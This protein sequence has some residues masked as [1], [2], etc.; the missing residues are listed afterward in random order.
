MRA[1]LRKLRADRGMSQQEAADQI[2]ITK[3]YYAMIEAGQRQR[4]MDLTLAARIAEVFA[5]TLDTILQ[6]ESELLAGDAAETA[7]KEES[8]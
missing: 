4:K 8:A 6:A 7:A 3:Q 2:G 1:Y 5:V